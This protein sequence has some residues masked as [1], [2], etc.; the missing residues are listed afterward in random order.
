[1][2]GFFSRKKKLHPS[3]IRT[4][5]IADLAPL[6]RDTNDVVAVDG[7][8]GDDAQKGLRNSK[9]PGAVASKHRGTSPNL[10]PTANRP[11]NR[12]DPWF[13]EKGL[14]ATLKTHLKAGRTT[15]FQ[16]NG[17]AYY[18][19][20]TVAEALNGQRRV[21]NLE[22]LDPRAVIEFFESDRGL[23]SGKY[24]MRFDAGLPTKTYLYSH[25]Y[26]ETEDSGRNRPVDETGRRLKSLKS[27]KAHRP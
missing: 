19:L 20:D 17:R 26:P 15:A 27:I 13:D 25:L 14:L 12:N 9:F 4:I 11:L 23:E 3:G 8:A 24:A 10:D 6:W 1:M 2:F 22:L 7:N 18:T 5:P 16:Y 21:K